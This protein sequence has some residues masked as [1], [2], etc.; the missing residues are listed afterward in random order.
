MLLYCFL[1]LQPLL[2]SQSPLAS[3]FPKVFGTGLGDTSFSAFDYFEQTSA[4]Q[5][6]YS[7][8]VAGTT[9]DRGLLGSATTKMKPFFA[10]YVGNCLG[11]LW[12]KYI[13][14]Q[15]SFRDVE[16][17]SDGTSFIALGT[18][19]TVKSLIIV[20][21]LIDASVLYA[22][23]F[24]SSKTAPYGFPN[25]LLTSSNSVI[26][27]TQNARSGIQLF[28]LQPDSSTIS[29]ALQ[30]ETMNAKDKAYGIILESTSSFI[31]SLSYIQTTT[32]GPSTVFS[33]FHADTGAS[34]AYLKIQFGLDPEAVIFSRK[35][36]ALKE[37]VGIVGYAA[38]D[39]LLGL[40]M[41]ELYHQQP[42]T[43]ITELFSS[44]LTSLTDPIE[45]GAILSVSVGTSAQL[46]FVI[47]QVDELSLIV[48]D[49]ILSQIIF[50]PLKY[51]IDFDQ[52]Y[53]LQAR[54]YQGSSS[55]ISYLIFFSHMASEIKTS[56]SN[57]FSINSILDG[58]YGTL[59]YDYF[60]PL[61]SQY[62]TCQV[63][64]AT[65][66]PIQDTDTIY[67]VL[68][69]LSSV[70][71]TKAASDVN[72]VNYLNN[73]Q[74][75]NLDSS[76]VTS[77]AQSCQLTTS[78][79]DSY[80][81]DISGTQVTNKLYYKINCPIYQLI[82]ITPFTARQTC[83][84]TRET[85]GYS[86]ASNSGP[87]VTLSTTNGQIFIPQNFQQTQ[88]EIEIKGQPSISSIGAIYEKFQLFGSESETLE[89][90][91]EFDISYEMVVGQKMMIILKTEDF[92]GGMSLT[93]QLIDN[94]PLPS[95]IQFSQDK[96]A[97]L[98]DPT[99]PSQVGLYYLKLIKRDTCT[100][101]VEKFMDV[102]VNSHAVSPIRLPQSQGKSE[103][104]SE[105]FKVNADKISTIRL[106]NVEATGNVEKYLE[107]EDA[108]SFTDLSNDSRELILNPSSADVRDT[109]Y[110]IIYTVV[111][112]SMS[113]ESRN[114]TYTI[115][116]L[117]QASLNIIKGP[118]SG[119]G[120]TGQIPMIDPDAAIP[121]N[122]SKSTIYPIKFKILKVTSKGFVKVVFS[123][124]FQAALPA[125]FAPL[126]ASYF[127]FDLFINGDSENAVRLNAS[128]IEKDVSYSIVAFQMEFASYQSSYQMYADNLRVRV[129]D[130]ITV[131][132]PM[133][134]T[135]K[136]AIAVLYAGEESLKEVPQKLTAGR[137]YG[138]NWDSIDLGVIRNRGEQDDLSTLHTLKSHSGQHFPVTNANPQLFIDPLSQILSGVC[139]MIFLSS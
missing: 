51:E 71:T 105:V 124:D 54:I 107:S 129:V 111:D 83:G 95:F 85:F 121:G 114:T 113:K 78:T 63:D 122:S 23:E 94:S 1:L 40:V 9:T 90:A 61:N 120:G 64:S 109:P 32:A 98:I 59:Y 134:K 28:S 68:S 81:F 22:F 137:S 6:N 138:L 45:L 5:S 93:I 84:S 60:G 21:K 74:I 65:P 100:Q 42:S 7:L 4:V 20:M 87:G 73:I 37:Y 19:G 3:H 41:V 53:P 106:P 123:C 127:Y 18:G 75:K 131:N 115:E 15:R 99:S 76:S 102:F 118:V 101:Q 30:S 8:A 97:L 67:P 103:F 12:G 48:Y 49:H 119:S 91:T 82:S 96:G 108:T 50:K 88:F 25:I 135:S 62:Q 117:V 52:S 44:S 34:D 11:Y 33:I 128:V 39:N 57:S 46:A 112:P 104:G 116:V 26:V 69:T 24:S 132:P 31:Y 13:E 35:K 80:I 133:G 77:I 92:A 56:A 70:F 66:P 72:L 79:Q 125:F 17:N 14:D 16:F 2:S 130:Q 10:V 43:P 110:T 58:Q 89:F 47:K 38:S 139:L 86:I 126:E 55:Q 27:Q 136:D 29:W 36:I